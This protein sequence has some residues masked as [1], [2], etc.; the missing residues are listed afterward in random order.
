MANRQCQLWA[1]IFVVDPALKLKTTYAHIHYLRVNVV[2]AR[3][4]G[5]VVL[6]LG[7]RRQWWPTLYRHRLAVYWWRVHIPSYTQIWHKALVLLCSYPAG[8]GGVCFAIHS[9]LIS[10]TLS[11]ATF[12][13][14][15]STL[16]L[17][18]NNWCW[19]W[20]TVYE[21]GRT[22]TQLVFFGVQAYWDNSRDHLTTLLQIIHAVVSITAYTLA[23]NMLKDWWPGAL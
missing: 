10:L 11:R 1:G 4:W 15:A 18:I 5:I 2:G 6:M 19:C 8:Y 23:L 13:Y 22:S 3:C 14:I 16:T 7:H 9:R 17:N 12:S 20:S 21:A